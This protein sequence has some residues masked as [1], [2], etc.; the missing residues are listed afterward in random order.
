MNAGTAKESNDWLLMN[1]T[2]LVPL[3]LRALRN[4]AIMARPSYFLGMR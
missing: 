4:L 1:A 2:L 3:Q